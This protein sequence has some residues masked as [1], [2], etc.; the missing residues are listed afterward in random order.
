MP[1]T[2]LGIPHKWNGGIVR[3]KRRTRER[4]A[5]RRILVGLP[6]AVAP[7]FRIATVVN[8]VKNHQGAFGRGDRIMLIR[9]HR[10][11]RIGHHHP[12][13][14]RVDGI[15]VFKRRIQAQPHP[16]GSL[17][18]LHLQMLRGDHNDN[19]IHGTSSF[20][21]RRHPQGKGGFTCAGGSDGQEVVRLGV[22]IFRQRLLLPYPKI[23]A[24]FL[25][26]LRYTRSQS[27]HTGEPGLACLVTGKV[28]PQSATTIFPETADSTIWSFLT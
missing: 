27:G 28:S 3:P 6:D 1:L 25:R 11:L 24:H 7:A 2:I 13:V 17:R 4:Q 22:Q 10:H 5:A 23:A 16:G 15:G 14:L 12:V 19:A 8:L 18:P 9:V 21:L 26:R 20:Q